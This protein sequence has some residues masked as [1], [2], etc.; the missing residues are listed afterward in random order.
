MMPL[1]LRLLRAKS[2]RHWGEAD[3]F[4]TASSMTDLKTP[5][6]KGACGSFSQRSADSLS[7]LPEAFQ[8]L[9]S[10]YSPASVRMATYMVTA[11]RGMNSVAAAAASASSLSNSHSHRKSA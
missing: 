3:Y 4:G 5:S 1:S 11:M 2:M 6:Q 9:A 8:T 10:T 7:A